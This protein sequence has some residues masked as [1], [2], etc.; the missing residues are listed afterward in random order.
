MLSPLRLV[1]ALPD[2]CANLWDMTVGP[3]VADMSRAPTSIIDEGPQR[4]VHRYR[5][6]RLA[7]R[8]APVLLVPPLAAPASCFDL[9][10]SCSLSQ[11]LLALGYPTYLADYGPISFSDRQLG[12]EHCGAR[13]ACCPESAL[14]NRLR[15][16]LE[17]IR[18]DD[19][20]EPAVDQIDL[21]RAHVNP[22]HLMPVARQAGGA[23]G[24]HVSQAEDAN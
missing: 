17:D 9:R 18:F 2:A 13:I 3:G 16:P 12:L 15:N 4:T 21:C 7:Y 22:D 14:A 11:H 1:E 10:R 24:S 23:N 5:P 6:T 20:R 19:R 8:H